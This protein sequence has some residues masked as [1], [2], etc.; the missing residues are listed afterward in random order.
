MVAE[1]LRDGLSRRAFIQAAGV[2][3]AGF[4]TTIVLP[5]RTG[6]APQAGPGI[7]GDQALQKLLEGNKRFVAAKASRPNQTA[8][9]RAD[10]TKGQQPFATILGC[11]DSRVP[12]EIVFDQGLGDLFVIR[13]AGNIAD[14]AGL[15]SMEY[16]A[17]V[18][19]APL[20]LVLGHEKCGAVEAAL[21]GDAVPGHIAGLV[22]AIRPAAERAKGQPGDALDNAVRANVAA[23]V[24]QLKGS[25]PILAD[26]VEKGKLKIAGGRYDLDT[27]VVEVIA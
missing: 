11:S 14:D 8:K 13:A 10:L 26:L 23:V 5:S 6:A 3:V 1:H 24:A 12:P 20:L 17:A 15:G 7:T 22:K 25:K 21:K 16:A 18:L 9:R 19:G 27:G 4:G 2:L